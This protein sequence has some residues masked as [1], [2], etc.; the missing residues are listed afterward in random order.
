MQV[1]AGLAPYGWHNFAV[2]RMPSKSLNLLPNSMGSVILSCASEVLQCNATK[3]EIDAHIHSNL[4]MYPDFVERTTG[5]YNPVECSKCLLVQKLI[6][7]VSE[8]HFEI[9]RIL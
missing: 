8:I 3:E 5:G 6:I 2:M 7:A 1:Q 9:K 4:Q